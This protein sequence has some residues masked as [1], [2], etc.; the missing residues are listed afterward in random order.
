MCDDKFFNAYF[1]IGYKRKYTGTCPH[2]LMSFY[3]FQET[4]DVDL[5]KPIKSFISIF[6]SVSG[7]NELAKIFSFF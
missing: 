2:T 1:C 7:G 5:V 4:S 3:S 6:R